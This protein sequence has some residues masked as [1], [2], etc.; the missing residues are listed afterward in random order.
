MI[1][2]DHGH[3]PVLRDPQ[4]ALGADP[5]KGPP[6]WSKRR[7]SGREKI[8]LKPERPANRIPGGVRIPGR[9]FATCTGRPIDLSQSRH[10]LRLKRPPRIPTGRAAGRA[11]FLRIEQNR[12]AGAADEGHARL[13][14]ARFPTP[15]GK[16]TN[17]FENFRR[18][19]A[20]ADLG[21]S[22]LSIR[23]PDL[24]QLDRPDAMG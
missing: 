23:D 20:R 7:D 8:V 9:G 21:I 15:P 4:H 3:T 10:D 16:N 22:A 17:E 5:D 24:I 19:S 2:A 11:R 12:Q 14:F 6:R 1:I 13:I 18:S